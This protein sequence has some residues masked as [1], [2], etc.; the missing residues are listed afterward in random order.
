MS[1]GDLLLPGGVPIGT[2]G[3]KHKH[4]QEI[5]ELPGGLK[6]A[7]HLF[8]DLTKGGTANTPPRYPGIG[9]ALPGGGWVGLRRISKSGPP[10]IDV[11]VPGIPIKQLKFL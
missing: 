6:E 3:G 2:A 7:D 11:D 9:V 5:R 8:D 1:L 4:E 10:T